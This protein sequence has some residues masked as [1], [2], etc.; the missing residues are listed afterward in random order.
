MLGIHVQSALDPSATAIAVAPAGALS[1]SLTPLHFNSGTYAESAN[2][3]EINDIW[4]RC[5]KC[6]ENKVSYVFTQ[7]VCFLCVC[8]F[9]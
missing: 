8:V 5:I 2:E 9:I 6:V 7:Y 1:G 3:S 4:D